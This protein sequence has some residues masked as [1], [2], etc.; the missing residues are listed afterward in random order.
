MGE[1]IASHLAT[2]PAGYQFVSRRLQYIAAALVT[3]RQRA[4]V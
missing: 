1:Y 3:P 2:L 4:E